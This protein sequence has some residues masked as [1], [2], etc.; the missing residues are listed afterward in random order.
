M[1][2]G[3][4]GSSSALGE[5]LAKDLFQKSVDVLSIGRSHTYYCQNTK[6]FDLNE[7]SQ[8]DNV[9]NENLDVL[10]LISWIQKPRNKIAMEKNFIAYSKLIESA[11]RNNVK[12]VFIST[13]GTIGDCK[14]IHVYYKKLVENLLTANDQILRPAT[15]YSDGKIIGK[16]SKSNKESVFY[17]KTNL[18]IPVVELKNVI[19]V[20]NESLFTNV[21]INPNLI[22]KTVA[23]T[24]PFSTDIPRYFLN[25]KSNILNMFFKQLSLVKISFAIDI[26]DSWY[27]IFGLQESLIKLPNSSGLDLK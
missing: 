18:R 24:F 15:I 5:A 26:V 10:V 17:L 3:I 22:D 19:N 7:P 2:I 6:F 27:A 14:S 11:H 4:L 9:F 13:L 1:K 8:A 21:T 23:L 16:L 20:I 12:V 25:I